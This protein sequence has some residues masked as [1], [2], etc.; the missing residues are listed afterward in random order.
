MAS[1]A[2]E[3]GLA[4]ELWRPTIVVLLALL[5]LAILYLHLGNA[6]FLPQYFLMKQ[7]IPALFVVLAFTLLVRGALF[8]PVARLRLSALMASLEQVPIPAISACVVVVGVAGAWLVFDFYPLSMDEFWARADGLIFAHGAP[9]AHIPA[10]W[11]SY[12]RALQPVFLHLLPSGWWS[13]GYLPVNALIQMALGPLASPLL[14]AVSVLLAASIARQLMP[15]YRSA[16]LVCALLLASSAQLLLAAMTPYAMSAHLAFNLAWLSLILRRRASA[17]LLAVPI[18]LLAIGLHQLVFFPLFALPFLLEGFVS[19]ERRWA[20][21]HGLTILAGILLWS[22]YDS[23]TAAM[24]SVPA[25]AGKARDT[26]ALVGKMVAM[27]RTF[28][29]RDADQMAL[30]LLRFLL[31]QNPL[32]IVLMLASAGKVMRDGGPLRAAWAGILLPP[33]FMFFVLPYQGHGWGYRYLHDEL[34]NVALLATYAWFQIA[35]R[36][37]SAWRAVF[38]SALILSVGILLPLR[39]YQAWRQAAPYVAANRNLNRLN[40]DVVVIDAPQ[41]AYTWD[42]VRNSPLMDNSPKRLAGFMLTDDQMAI[43][44]KQYRVE[45]FTDADA[46][47]LR[48]PEI[49]LNSGDEIPR[50][51]C[52][53]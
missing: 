29:L 19:G 32:A 38:A 37:S 30:N 15:E 34:G 43:L 7:D 20:V 27:V 48:I 47:R 6:Q 46:A 17:H 5:P 26:G 11:Q 33:L 44:C 2:I 18:G 12:S 10:A 49:R 41:H 21:A 14:A 31:W 42:L 28:D 3:R 23:V 22:N 8:S 40:A 25:A 51:T 39:A 53:N 24:M 36:E 45:F 13:S 16:P 52:R 9:M 1:K 4:A 50:T 35:D